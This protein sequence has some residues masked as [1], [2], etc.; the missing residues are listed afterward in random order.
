[1]FNRLASPLQRALWELGWKGLRETQVQALPLILDTRDDVVISAATAAGKTE[2]AF[3]PLLTRLWQS[4]AVAAGQG[5]FDTDSVVA[6]KGVIL[7]VAPVK[8]LINDQVER[9]QLFCE[10]MD[11]PVYPWHG[12]V[13]PTLRKRFFADP[14]GV[15]LITPES[16][17]AL[18][19][20]RGSDLRQ[21]FA[22][23]QAVVVDEL[24]AFIGNVRGRQLQSLLHRLEAQLGQRVQRIGLSATLGDMGLAAEFLRPGH[25]DAVHIV[26][27]PG[28]KRNLQL[29]VKAILQPNA[30][31]QNKQDAHWTI[32]DELFERLRGANY[33]V[34][35][36]GVGMVE[37][38]ADALRKRCEDAGL[39]VTYFPHHGRL[40][41]TEREETEAEL[42][43]G[44]LPVSAICTTTLEMGIDIGAIK[45]VVQIG[46][47]QTVA[48]LCQRIGRAGRREGDVAVLWQYCI[49]ETLSPG[50]DCVSSLYQDLVQ[51][52]AVIQLFLA[53][54][55]EPPR[56]GALH[57][58][59]LIQQ[60]LS[61]VGERHGV[62]AAQAYTML[63]KTGP[64]TDVSEANFIALLRAMVAKDLLMQD[65][66]KL[67]LHG[68]RGE[69]MVNH[70]TFYAAFPDSQEYRLRQGG[71]ELG[72]L[73]LQGT[74][75]RGDVITF[76][77]RRWRIEAIDHEKRLVE[78]TVSGMG[79]LPR[80]GGSG[81]PVHRRVRQEMR[82]ILAGSEAP[83]WLDATAQ[84]LLRDAQRQYKA[85]QLNEAWYVVE[86]HTIY[87]FLWEGD[88]VQEA[89]S[90]L[91]MSQGLAATN[92]GICIQITHTTLN[93]VAECLLKIW[94]QPCPSPEQILERRGVGDTEKWDWALPNALLIASY[95]S[96]ALAL[97]EAHGL[98]QKLKI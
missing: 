92:A 2:A 29:A 97:E 1:M 80:T 41:K 69:K 70:Y 13:G 37:F 10:R 86:G 68:T 63:C 74:S 45:G 42:K 90:V 52:V 16:L 72:T 28:E 89:L 61:L 12:D 14:R 5:E 55:Y 81:T 48:S 43:R 22:E 3:L 95:A 93:L 7:Y 60:V 49:A 35:P 50:A 75:A 25:G 27:T 65:A 76:A 73:P 84:S 66:N 24:H 15:V 11:I 78:L 64:F 82:A 40:A 98:C 51:A 79:K 36:A 83:V 9:L 30:D 94:A 21:I 6:P 34:F 77:G 87:L 32:A 33:L 26:T 17:E 71:K 31:T 38:Y 85:L 96:R 18:L 88:L 44:N 57:Y 56:V 91:L 8:A 23:L 58:S 39:P 47:P 54:W 53:K 67:L 4:A 20:K 19:F 59:T 46:A 62:T